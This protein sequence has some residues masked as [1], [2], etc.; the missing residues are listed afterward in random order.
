MSYLTNEQRDEL[1]ELIAKEVA[2]TGTVD[3]DR[4]EVILA[5]VLENATHV[6]KE[7]FFDIKQPHRGVE[8][9]TFKKSAKGLS[10]GSS[11]SNVLKRIPPDGIPDDIPISQSTSPEVVGEAVLDYYEQELVESSA[12]E[13]GIDDEYKL[14]IL[15][16]N[17]NQNKIAYWE[18]V[19]DIEAASVY[20]WRWTDKGLI[21]S[22]DGEDIYKWYYANQRQL[23]YRY[24]A[25]ND[26]E[27]I[28]LPEYSEHNVNIFTRTEIQELL[29]EACEIGDT[30]DGSSGGVEEMIEE[31]FPKPEESE[32][33]QP[34]LNDFN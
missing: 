2:L 22:K 13:L 14:A 23:F 27:V 17:K 15:F 24:E 25:P 28:E 12:E 26:V 18:E 5:Q 30:D 3:G 31:N 29:D 1:K 4:F 33:E 19:I 20:D 9:K 34:D 11:L 8:A 32:D 7:K 10:G 16:R 21:A 6:E